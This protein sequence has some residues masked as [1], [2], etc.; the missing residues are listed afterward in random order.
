MISAC[1]TRQEKKKLDGLHLVL[2]C[3]V[4]TGHGSIK[5]T[6]LADSGANRM[7]FID[8]TFAREKKFALLQLRNPRRL[9]MVDR[10]N[11]TPR[12]TSYRHPR[13]SRRTVLF[14]DP[15]QPAPYCLR[16]TVAATTRRHDFMKKEY[17]HVHVG[18]LPSDIWN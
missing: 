5:T 8:Q 14:Y 13:T 4:D 1:S 12:A 16:D 6:A 10:T 18:L 15:A 17:D 7:A 9:E 11:H 2:P 3:S